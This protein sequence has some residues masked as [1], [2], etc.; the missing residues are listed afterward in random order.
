M[1]FFKKLFGDKSTRDL[2]EVNPFVDKIKEAYNQVFNIGADKKYTVKELAETIMQ[3]METKQELK[4]LP[5]RNEVVNAYSDH[6]K[7]K[8]I[9]NIS[10]GVSLIDGITKM[11]E[12]VKLYGAKKTP[13][14]KNIEIYE[15]LPGIWVE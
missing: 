1:N 5:A 12:W 4:F 13:K 14:F 8:K 9:F 3:V 15:N 11:V 7:A 10:E 2:K 6:S